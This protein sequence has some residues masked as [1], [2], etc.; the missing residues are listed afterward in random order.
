MDSCDLLVSADSAFA[1]VS[2]MEEATRPKPVAVLIKFQIDNNEP[3]E[4]E[5]VTPLDIFFPQKVFEV[6]VSRKEGEPNLRFFLNDKNGFAKAWARH[7]V[8]GCARLDDDWDFTLGC[9]G[10]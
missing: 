1:S 10:F 4:M 3:C 8:D 6:R 7:V 5:G 2:V 9:S